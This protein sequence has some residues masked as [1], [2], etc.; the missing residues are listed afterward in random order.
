MERIEVTGSRLPSLTLES[1]SPVNV[2]SAQ[3]IRWD[4]ITN[5]ANIVNQLPAAYTDQGNNLSNGATGTSA[6]NLRNLGPSR[7]LVL[8]DGRRLPAG[9]P[10]YWPTD[11]NVI[12][13]PLIERVEVLT[14]GASAVYGS[15]AIAGVVNFI[16]NDHF[17]GVQVQWN[18]NGF[19]HHQQD[20]LQSLINRNAGQSGRL[21]D[22]GQRGPGRSNAE[23]QHAAGRELCR[24]QGQR[25]ALLQLPPCRASQPGPAQFQRVRIV[26]ECDGPGMRWRLEYERDRLLLRRAHVHPVHRRR[27]RRQHKAV[28]A[29]GR[30]QF[31]A[32]QL[33]PAPGNAVQLQ[34]IR[35]L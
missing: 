32:A 5:T 25:D 22:S 12:P 17:E 24:R 21:P 3:D 30:L 31:C 19:N 4:G 27:R 23:L 7:T 1:V 15:D 29:R 14:G 20:T 9:S 34:R 11:V 8:I 2:I 18:A 6:I 16:M 26:V 13:A 10:Q 28:D 35:P 33:F